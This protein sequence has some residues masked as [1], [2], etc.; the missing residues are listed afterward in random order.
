[1]HEQGY[2][3]IRLVVLLTILNSG[4]A[5][6]YASLPGYICMILGVNPNKYKSLQAKAFVGKIR[7]LFSVL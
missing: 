5:V 3:V 4:D 1:L 6:S 7:A 2:S